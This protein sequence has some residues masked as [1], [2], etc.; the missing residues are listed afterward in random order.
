MTTRADATDGGF[1]ED[2]A[3]DVALERFRSLVNTVDDGIYQLDSDGRFVAVNEAIL[4]TTGYER[5]ELVGEHVSLV[6][7]DRD[8]AHIQREIETRLESGRERNPIFECVALARDGTRV[9]WELRTN[10]LV[11]DGTF[12]GSVGVVRDVGERTR[13][14]ET[15]DRRERQLEYERD[16]TDRIVQTSPAGLLVLDTEAR[17]TRMN[18]RAKELLGVADDTRAVAPLD[19]TVYDEDGREL[20]V[21]EHPFARA[22]ETG[23]PVYDR[24]LQVELPDGTRRWLSVNA[25][26]IFDDEGE[27]HRVVTTG[28]DVTALKERERSLERRRG[29]LEAELDEIYGRIT[30]GFYSL[31]S[32]WTFTYAN[33]RAKDLIG[34]GQGGLIGKNMW[35]TFEWAADSK[36]KTKYETAME[37]QE[38]TSFELFYPAPLESWYEIHAYPSETGLSVYF[39]DVSDRKERERKLAESERRYRTLAEYFPNGVVTLFDDNLEYT[40]A[41]GQAFDWL[42]VDPENVEGKTVGNAWNENVT[43]ALQPVLQTALAG[44]E[45]SVELEYAGREWVVWAVPITDDAGAVFAGMTMAQDITEQK[46]RERHL[47]ETKTQLEAATE[48]GAIGTW[49]WHV[50]EDRFVTGPTFAETFG[51]DPDDAEDGV[52]I[53]RLISSVHE[54]D[55]ERVLESIEKAVETCGEYEAVYR[56]WNAED[57]LR[58]VVAR[59]HVDC[60]EDGNPQTFPGALAD[61]TDRKRAELEVEKQS[62][63]LETLFRVLPVGVVVAD[64][65][66]SLLRANE[67]ARHLWGGGVFDAESVEEYEKYDAVW[68]DTGEPVAPDEW[69]MSQVLQGEEVTEPNVYQIQAFD[70]E[71][72]IIMEHGM[73]VRD[74]DGDV[75]RA[76]VTL[77]DITE[78]REYQRR[79]EDAVEK[80]ER[81]NERLEQFAYAASHDLQEPLRMVSSY[82]QLIDRRYGDGL[83]DDAEE[84]LAFAV[85]GA[86]RMRSMIDALLEY[87]RIETGGD[88]I[89]PIHLENVFET[90]IDDLQLRVEETDA[91]VT[92][93]DLPRVTGDA[94]QLRRVFQNLLSNALEYSGD[95]P[96][97]I[98]VD[99]ERQGEEWLISV[100]DRGIG[101]DSANHERVFEIFHRLH[102]RE[103]HDGSGVGLALCQRIIER[104]GGEIWVDSE[105]DEGTT[106]SFTLPALEDEHG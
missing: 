77:T 71:A 68:E 73:P 57:E 26:P 56:V 60:D 79:L 102:S 8:A 51:L 61:I 52:S 96:P 53:D 14:T 65:D 39:R 3:G 59:G 40:L 99:A 88:P 82:L 83:D 106:F 81:S 63:E 22:L 54:A 36:L 10:V 47:R 50:P 35:E 72:R 62:R 67:T 20:S 29:E 76:V 23:K 45:Q 58:W 100:H 44:H 11:E 13:S 94:T 55:R 64:A 4:E 85:D 104:H 90:V 24:T 1:W 12:Q 34:F 98:H 19:R 5:A 89:E 32:D 103:E 49:E 84:F 91:D 69:T 21:D 95:E 15:L 70:D 105:P 86:E 42:P 80:L 78:R 101:I 43:D 16:L 17:I 7:E 25:A 2:T 18:D 41:A 31:D 9:P 38:S 27:I 28:E 37:T 93:D 6:V 48:A 33:E 30:D 97:R 87:S 92:A 66:G 46:A 75:T 74:E